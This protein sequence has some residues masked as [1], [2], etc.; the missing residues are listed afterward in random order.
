MVAPK[1]ITFGAGG[2]TNNLYSL[3]SRQEQENSLDVVTSMIQVF[4][5][6]VY[7]LLDPRASLS[8]VTPYVTM[9]F[10]TILRN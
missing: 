3:N 10:D 5:F 7:A 2:G 8:F 9:N 6:T 4:D 1:G